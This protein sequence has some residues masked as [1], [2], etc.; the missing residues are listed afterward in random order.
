MEAKLGRAVIAVSLVLLSVVFF[1]WARSPYLRKQRRWCENAVQ[2]TCGELSGMMWRLGSD[3]DVNRAIHAIVNLRCDE[4]HEEPS[5]IAV[6][7]AYE[8][9]ARE[10]GGPDSERIAGEVSAIL[11]RCFE[12]P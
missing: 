8:T 12:R 6:A 1:Q 11:D 2:L 9:L 4:L 7:A 5:R 3:D 10:G